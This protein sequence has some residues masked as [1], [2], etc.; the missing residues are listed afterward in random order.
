MNIKNTAKRIF[1]KQSGIKDNY[2]LKYFI[3]IMLHNAYIHHL[4]II[5]WRF[6]FFSCHQQASLLMGLVHSH[7]VRQVEII[8]YFLANSGEAYYW[9]LMSMN[10][11][12]LKGCLALWEGKIKELKERCLLNETKMIEKSRDEKV[13]ECHGALLSLSCVF[14]WFPYSIACPHLQFQSH[15]Q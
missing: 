4:F 6:F 15:C 8:W 3:I 12:S 9:L 13:A 7:C 2:L 14:L 5:L 1:L 10:I 11:S